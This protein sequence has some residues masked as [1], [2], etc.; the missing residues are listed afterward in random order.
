MKTI[1]CMFLI[2]GLHLQI[3]HMKRGMR[4]FSFWLFGTTGLAIRSYMD[5]VR[6][7]YL[8]DP[9]R[10]TIESDFYT[11]TIRPDPTWSD[12]DWRSDP[13]RTGDPVRLLYLPP[14]RPWPLE[15]NSFKNTHKI[16]SWRRHC[17]WAALV[18]PSAAR[19]KISHLVTSLSRSCVRTAS[20]CLSQVV[21]KFGTSS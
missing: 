18:T 13:T 11:C 19:A 3:S 10:T 5:P 8:H 20:V 9:T 4:V 16:T 14:L 6:L 1:V 2:W 12:S 17:L 7:L 21:N 15:K